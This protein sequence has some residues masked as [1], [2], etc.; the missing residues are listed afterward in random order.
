MTKSGFA[1][2]RLKSFIERIERLQEERD[3]LNSDIREVYGE[4]KANGFDIK[5]MRSIVRDRKLDKAD[6]HEHEAV[7]DLYATTLNMR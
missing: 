4:A 5:I 2:E 1:K 6:Y 7:Y 3:A